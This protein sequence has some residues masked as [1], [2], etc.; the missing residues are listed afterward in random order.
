[1]RKKTDDDEQLPPHHNAEVHLG[2]HTAGMSHTT[3]TSIVGG[4][5]D[6][7]GTSHTTGTSNTIN[8]S[9]MAGANTPPTT[10]ALQGGTSFQAHRISRGQLQSRRQRI[11]ECNPATCRQVSRNST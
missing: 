1:M 11:H 9:N 7:V 2:P 5:S 10:V 3:G 8:A 6:T 4:A